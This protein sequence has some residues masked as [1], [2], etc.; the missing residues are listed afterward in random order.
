MG[1][2]RR[3]SGP[4]VPLGIPHW[5]EAFMYK[6]K[7]GRQVAWIVYRAQEMRGGDL[8]IDSFFP[9]FTQFIYSVNMY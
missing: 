3:A 8:K 9:P 1:L 2:K 4:S 5:K 7:P 6:R